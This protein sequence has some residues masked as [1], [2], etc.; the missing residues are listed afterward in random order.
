MERSSTERFRAA[1]DF[2]L[3]H[4]ADYETA[5]REFRWPKLDRF[6]WALDYFDEMARGNDRVA[7]WVVDDAGEVKLSFAE[8]SRRSSQVANFLR[9][10]GVRRGEVRHVVVGDADAGK[11][12]ALPGDYT[13]IVVGKDRP[14]WTNLD[15]AR[16][17]RADF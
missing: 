6:N 5:R 7:L 2:L 17:A 4:R 11:L 12:D 10:R 3:A 14:G 13:R 15:G 16:S 8:L 9:A 1:R